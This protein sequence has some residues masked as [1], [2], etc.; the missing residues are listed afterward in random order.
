MQNKIV[1]AFEARKKF[2]EI[3]E[4]VGYRGESVVVEKNGRPLVAIVPIKMLTVWEALRES[5]F[6]DMRQ[7]AAR[8][9]KPDE[10]IDL[11]IDEAIQAA[12]AE[13]KATASV[14]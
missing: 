13:R 6:D 2:G 8:V 10:E 4:T 14:S 9:N 11:L 12:R 3:I 5:V 1:G 7:S